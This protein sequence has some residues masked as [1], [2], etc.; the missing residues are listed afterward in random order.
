MVMTEQELEERIMRKACQFVLS[1]YPDDVDIMDIIDDF[2][3][4][5]S[6]RNIY[7]SYEFL[8]DAHKSKLLGDIPCNF[9]SKIK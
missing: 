7:I 4:K 3:I 8:N 2:Q 1:S 5:A 9:I 6:E